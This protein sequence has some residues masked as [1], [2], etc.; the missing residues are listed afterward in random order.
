MSDHRKRP[1]D[2]SQAA[3]LDFKRDHSNSKGTS[4]LLSDRQHDGDDHPTVF[5]PVN[6]ALLGFNGLHRHGTDWA[7]FRRYMGIGL[8]FHAT[9]HRSK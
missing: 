7:S 2:F 8:P 3:T 1:R 9:H 6:D 5:A 4:T